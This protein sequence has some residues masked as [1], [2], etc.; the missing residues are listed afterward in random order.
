MWTVYGDVILMQFLTFFVFDAT[1]FCLLFVNKL[2]QTAWPP[3]TMEVFNGRLDM[4]LQSH[5]VHDWIDLEF[6]AKRTR[7]I[8][9]LI[10]FPFV[11][12][13]LLIVS[14]STVFA[15]YPPCL[16]ILIAQ[17]ISLCVVFGCAIML[18]WAATAA[19]DTAKQKLADGVIFARGHYANARG[20]YAAEQ[21]ETL[22]S[23]VD[24]LKEGAFSPFSQQPLVRA[25]LL[26]LG[27]FGWNV[28]IENG[29]L[30]GL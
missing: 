20:H 24:Q 23:R 17:G 10:Y 1:L 7:C 12:I 16:T 30:P 26:P 6:V 11:L 3:K 29:M 8:G 27:T 5:L 22:S 14:R 21:L 18:W 28:L 13:A 2:R 25:V 9:S 19:R 15:N 4:R